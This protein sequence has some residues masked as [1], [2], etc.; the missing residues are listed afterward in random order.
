[1]PPSHA[2]E[3][4]GGD[5]VER[6]G[7]AAHAALRERQQIEPRELR[8]VHRRVAEDL[9]GL[10]EGG[11]RRLPEPGILV[12]GLPAAGG[13]QLL[14]VFGQALCQIQV[15]E[16][17]RER[18]RLPAGRA[19]RRG[20]AVQREQRPR[21]PPADAVYLRQAL[22]RALLAALRARRRHPPVALAQPVARADAPYAAVVFQ[23]VRLR[24]RQ[25]REARAQVGEHLRLFPAAEDDLVGPGDERGQGLGE[26]VRPPGGEERHIRR[27]EGRLQRAAVVLKAAHGD[28]DVPPAAAAAGQLQASGGGKGALRRHARR[29]AQQHAPLRVLRLAAIAEHAGGQAAD[30]VLLRGA[31]RHD[32]RAHAQLMRRGQQ[33]PGR[34]PAELE[35]LV[36]RIER[37]QREADGDVRPARQQ[38]LHDALFHAR[39]V[40]KAVYVYVPRA[41]QRAARQVLQQLRE[42]GGGVA[43][44]AAGGGLKGLHQQREVGELAAQRPAGVLRGGGEG[45]RRQRRRAQLVQRAQQLQLLLRRA[46]R[47]AVEAQRAGAALHRQGH[48]QKPPAGVQPPALARPQLRRHA[49]GEAGE[50]EHLGIERHPRPGHAREL[51]LGLVAVLLGHDEQPLP[52]P[53]EGGGAYLVHDERGLARARAACY[54]SKHRSPPVL[55]NT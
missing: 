15:V 23:L 3:V 44:R 1:M 53:G 47:T 7:Y 20:A 41:G 26:H 14:R 51:A 18:L 40:R 29:R 52:L 34:A 12:R 22:R 17:R 30:D 10:L 2:V 43:A 25:A 27:G 8:G 48:A 45:L 54:Q 50:G 39:E 35:H 36:V 42:L 11:H 32:V 19:R 46:P 6:H 55:P 38:R 49:P 16:K 24:V 37:V 21:R 9:R 13:F 31:R 4:A 5:H 28:G 33:P